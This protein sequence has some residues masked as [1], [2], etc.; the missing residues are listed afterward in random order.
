M[1]ACI[2]FI[3]LFLFFIY[4]TFIQR[5]IHDEVCSNALLMEYA[6]LTIINIDVDSVK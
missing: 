3:Y 5:S 6:V 2:N 4:A 1:W